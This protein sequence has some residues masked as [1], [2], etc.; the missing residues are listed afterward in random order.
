MRS[1]E[2]FFDK[3]NNSL[4]DI[5]Q[6]TVSILGWAFK[7]NTNDSRESASIDI[8]KKLLENNY[9]VNVY[10]PMVNEETIINDLNNLS[11]LNLQKLNIFSTVED[12]VQSSHAIC[13]LTEWDEFQSLDY[14]YLSELMQEPILFLDGRNIIQKDRIAKIFKNTQSIDT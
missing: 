11:V 2:R 7:K 8:A 1:K 4:K 13:I 5:K 14:T 3:I 12:A 9:S 6:P 10:D